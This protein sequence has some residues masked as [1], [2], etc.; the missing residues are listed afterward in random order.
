MLYGGEDCAISVLEGRSCVPG[1]FANCA[2]P[3][4]RGRDSQIQSVLSTD[5]LLLSCLP[6]FIIHLGYCTICVS[7]DISPPRLPTSPC[8]QTA[9][10][11]LIKSGGRRV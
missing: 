9:L 5:A 7:A 1:L 8:L 3:F 4:T 2:L 6:S 10:M 11:K